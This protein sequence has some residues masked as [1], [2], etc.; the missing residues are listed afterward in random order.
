MIFLVLRIPSGARSLMEIIRGGLTPSISI[1]ETGGSHAW[2]I[3]RRSVV[4][5][6]SLPRH[7]LRRHMRQRLRQR[8]RSAM[9]ACDLDASYMLW[10]AVTY[11][12]ACGRRRF[13]LAAN[14][15][16]CGESGLRKLRS[17]CDWLPPAASA[18]RC[19]RSSV[20]ALAEA[21]NGDA[22]SSWVYCSRCRCQT[23][24]AS[25]KGSSPV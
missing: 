24:A 3:R 7:Q 16:S 15:N 18:R 12:T 6:P 9:I 21:H 8:S 19:R 22:Q 4:H 23:E 13:Y 1:P 5:L 2:W 17:V 11:S 14:G 20:Q 10:G 25:G